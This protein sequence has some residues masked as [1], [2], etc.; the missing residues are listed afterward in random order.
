[1]DR[2]EQRLASLGSA[3]DVPPAPNLVPAVVA[4]LPDRHPRRRRR[5]ARRTVMIALAATLAFAGGAMAIP[6]SRHAI[7]RVLG[8]RGVQIERVPR[9]PQLPPSARLG[10]GNPLPLGRA[11]HA[12]SFTALLPPAPATAYLAYDLPGGRLSI[13]VGRV[14]IVEFRGT[15]TPY[16]FKL[17]GPGTQTRQLRVNGGP[18]VYISGTPHEL[19]I[20][21]ANGE[22]QSEHVR[23]AGNVLLWQQGPV[24]ARIEGA[25]T[26]AGALALARSLR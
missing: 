16:V 9:L 1:M 25:P 26:L 19:L 5:P 4:T 10:I 20:R 14:L 23:L 13:R 15:V 17:L 2:L 6:A 7:L 18:G 8:L 22:V 21:T 12:A 3:L 11:R 24:T